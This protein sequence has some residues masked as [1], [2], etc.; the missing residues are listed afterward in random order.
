M[1]FLYLFGDILLYSCL[2]LLIGHF[3]I[4]LI[5]HAYRPDVSFSVRW[6]RLLILMIPLF[7]SF[8]VVRIVLY[9]YED[10]GLWV[11]LRSV[12]FTFEAGNAWILMTLWSGLL[13]IVTTRSSLS[14]GHIKLG[15]FLLLAMV[16]TFAWSGHASSIKGAEGM[17]IHT[18]HAL[19]VFIWTGG[20]LVLGFSSKTDRNWEII[21]EWFRPLVALCFLIIVGS[22][23][24]LMSVVVSVEEYADSWIL[25]YGQALLWKHVLI[26]PVLIIGF[27]NG[28]WSYA[29]S[30][31]PFEVKQ[32]RM[33]I[34]GVFILLIFTA[35]ALLGQQEPPHSIK[36]TLKTSGAGLLSE[37]T[38]PSLG[39]AYSDVQ[40]EPTVTSIILVTISLLFGGLLVFV[41]RTTHDSIKTFYLGLGVSVSLFFAAL[42]SISVFL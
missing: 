37:I 26:L 28:K 42:Y 10:I 6:I 15:V 18:V 3:S 29:Y 27:M 9:L 25:P 11:T 16:A 2:A 38:F 12:L 8:S 36:D 40:F 23:I 4:Q 1:T 14:P 5:P 32:M 34:E 7:F 31:Q 39:F 22:G 20:L 41:I 21:L 17:L 13:L 24:Y 30:K 35:T 33:R 19:A